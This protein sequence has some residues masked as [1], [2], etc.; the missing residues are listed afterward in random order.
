MLS[1]DPKK[2]A[3]AVLGGLALAGALAG[4]SATTASTTN[5][6]TTPT[7]TGT[8][9]TGGSYKDG[10]YTEGGT[11]QSPGGTESIEVTLTLSG[12]VISAVEVTGKASDGQ[13]KV[14]QGQFESGISAVV[15][16]KKIDDIQVDKVAGSSLT[17]G[18]F[19]A[20]VK[21]IKADAAA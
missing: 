18:G 14:Y 10:T 11:Y 5:D 8:T 2:T 21:L 13:A 19:K 20:A 12:G 1:L 7:E 4:C 17:S 9:T 16:G 15:V 3:T 6:A